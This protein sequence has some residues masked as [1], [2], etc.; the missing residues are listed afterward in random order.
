MTSINDYKRFWDGSEVGWKLC[1][2]DQSVWLAEY[3]FD[4]SGPTENE[5]DSLIKFVEPFPEE[6]TD[7]MGGRLRGCDR[8][9]TGRPFGETELQRLK[10]SCLNYTLTE[11]CTDHHLILNPAGSYF[12]VEDPVVREQIAWR[13]IEVGCEIE[14]RS[15]R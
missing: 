14:K 2:F 6:S 5:F 13:M 10:S 15:L 11:V 9:S 7:E 12:F 3:T 1:Q 4:K 8:C